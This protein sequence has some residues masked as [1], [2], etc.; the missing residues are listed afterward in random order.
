[1]KEMVLD[2]CLGYVKGCLRNGIDLKS[3]SIV[4]KNGLIWLENL[5]MD[6]RIRNKME[7]ERKD[8]VVFPRREH[9]SENEFTT[10]KVSSKSSVPEIVVYKPNQEEYLKTISNS[11]R[12]GLL[13]SDRAGTW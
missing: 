6:F 12:A 3:W 7:N 5:K 4:E 8:P 9:A 11:R 2:N 10:T 13:G 1:M